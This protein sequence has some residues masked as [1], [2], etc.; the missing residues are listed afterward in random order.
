MPAKSH[1]INRVILQRSN[2]INIITQ[3]AWE[4][5]S[6]SQCCMQPVTLH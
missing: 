2:T 5:E 4:N 6:Q 1:S 3:L